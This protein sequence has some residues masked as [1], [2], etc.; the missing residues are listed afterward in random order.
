M[1]VELG[2]LATSLGEG[3]VELDFALG[4]DLLRR[5]GFVE[6]GEFVMVKLDRANLAYLAVDRAAVG[7][8]LAFS[9]LLVDPLD[10]LAP[11][12]VIQ[13]GTSQFL[14]KGPS[15]VLF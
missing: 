1:L 10:D 12:K 5:C 11:P 14:E 15:I 8:V 13:I 3:L 4:W 7:T 2:V 9:A 6:E